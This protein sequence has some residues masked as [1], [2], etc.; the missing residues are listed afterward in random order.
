MSKTLALALSVVLASTPVTAP[1]QSTNEDLLGQILAGAVVTGIIAKAI[2]DRKDR[3]REARREEER[4]RGERRAAAELSSRERWR[5]RE[6][7]GEISRGWNTEPHRKKLAVPGF[8]RRPLP[9][10]C[11]FDV[12]TSRGTVPV[13]GARCLHANFPHAKK[14][15]RACRVTVE[16]RYH[17][18]YGYGARCLAKSGWRV[19]TR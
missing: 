16:G 15:P 5:D 18:R 12:R 7:R 10:F 8:M 4:R 2:D 11:R 14:L 6:F 1:A 13:Y 19:A 9:E 17:D 3:E